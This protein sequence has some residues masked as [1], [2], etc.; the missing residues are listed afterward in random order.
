MLTTMQHT[1][2]WAG[3]SSEARG[4][5]PDEQLWAL[6]VLNAENQMRNIRV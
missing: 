2:D 6:L 1:K 4:L 3:R 5:E